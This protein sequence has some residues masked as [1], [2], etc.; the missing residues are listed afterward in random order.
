MNIANRINII[1]K[2]LYV[3]ESKV[4]IVSSLKQ[5]S[6]CSEKEEEPNEEILNDIS[7]RIEILETKFYIPRNLLVQIEP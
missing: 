6:M 2:K 5:F 7:R 4:G 1:Y 3:I